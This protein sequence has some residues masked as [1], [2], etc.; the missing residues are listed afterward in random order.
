VAGRPPRAGGGRGWAK[1]LGRAWLAAWLFLGFLSFP[2]A[3]YGPTL[4]R[5]LL[6][7]MAAAGIDGRN[8]VFLAAFPLALLLGVAVWLPLEAWAARATATAGRPP[9][10]MTRWTGRTRPPGRD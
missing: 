10:P 1:A 3:L 9:A 7:P 2:L 8:A 6:A 5:P 4:L